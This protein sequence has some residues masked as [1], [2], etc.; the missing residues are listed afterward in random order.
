MGGQ[1]AR[2]P[3]IGSIKT[4]N[5]IL[6]HRNIFV[7]NG[8]VAVVTMYDKSQ[9]R[10]GKSRYVF[11]CLPDVLSQLTAQ[12]LVYVLPFS[13][14]VGRR[15][16]DFLFGDEQGPWIKNQLSVAI[17]VVTAKHLGVRL[18]A[19]GWRQVAIAIGNEHLRKASQLW[20]QDDPDNNDEGVAV[21]AGDD[22]AEVERNLFQH[23]LVQQAAHGTQVA[24]HH[25]AIDGDFLSHLG[26]DLVNIYSQASRAWHSFL[27]LESRGGGQWRLSQ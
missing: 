5:S 8:R 11:R 4:R 24:Q 14:V 27:H 18:T 3:K 19:S 13:R 21:A 7:I 26:P 23:I 9:K 10:R 16:S 25:Y 17:A 1:P 6:S 2:G 15:T 20:G 12:Y 22:D